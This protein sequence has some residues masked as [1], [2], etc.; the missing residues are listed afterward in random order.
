MFFF[1]SKIIFFFI[2]FSSFSYG[3]LD[4]SCLSGKFTANISHKIGLFSLLKNELIISKGLCSINISFKKWNV[5]EKQWLI[6][7]CRMPIHIKYGTGSYD[8]FKRINACNGVEDPKNES[9]F[10]KKKEELDNI[11]SDEGLIFAEGLKEDIGS[12][13]G[14]VY[15]TYLILKSYLKDGIVYESASQNFNGP[16]PHKGPDLVPPTG[17]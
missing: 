5:F 13:H 4:E 10:C 6:D 9:E 15:C 1:K 17:P 2:L 7:Y 12:D 11:I 3:F 14:K 8:V 16:V